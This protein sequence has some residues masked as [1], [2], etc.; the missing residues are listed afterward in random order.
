MLAE[1]KTVSASY[2]DAVKAPLR[3]EQREEGGQGEEV[4]QEGMQVMQQEEVMQGEGEV[5]QQ[6]HPSPP[7]SPDVDPVLMYNC[8]LYGLPHVTLTTPP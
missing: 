2:W 6:E 4:T 8:V 5:L 1:G 7:V 3:A